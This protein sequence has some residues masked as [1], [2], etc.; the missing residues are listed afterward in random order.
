MLIRI[1]SSD[2]KNHIELSSTGVL[3]VQDLDV[4]IERKS[5]KNPRQSSGD[6]VIPG[7]DRGSSDFG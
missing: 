2:K 4:L 5:G 1:Q 3:F 6:D 7:K